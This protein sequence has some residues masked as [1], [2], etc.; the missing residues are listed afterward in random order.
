V[1]G[2]GRAADEF[3]TIAGAGAGGLIG[4]DAGA[5]AIDGDAAAAGDD[6]PDIGAGF[7]G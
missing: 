1:A 7:S 5:S 6:I 2:D 3:S 4:G